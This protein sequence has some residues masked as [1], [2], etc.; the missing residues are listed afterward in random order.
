LGDPSVTFDY[1]DCGETV[2]LQYTQRVIYAFGRPNMG[3]WGFIGTCQPSIGHWWIDWNPTDGYSLYATLTTR[4]SDTA[5]VFT[6]TGSTA[7]A[8]A[9]LAHADIALPATNIMV[10]GVSIGL[11]TVRSVAGNAVTFDSLV[12]TLPAQG[13]ALTLNYGAYGWQ[14]LDRDVRLTTL[15]KGNY[16]TKD[17][18]VP[19]A[20]QLAKG[21][22]IP[23][24]LFLAG[25][26]GWF[27]DL[28]WPA[29]DPSR[30]NFSY[31][32]IPAGYRY[33]HGIDPPGSDTIR[34]PTIA[35]TSIQVF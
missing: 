3:N 17:A 23:K 14:E 19:A 10:G 18:G 27:G 21:D 34:T 4:T 7:S 2:G 24:S 32:A 29:F 12:G 25:K 15:L 5:G 16:N 35:T 31:D 11:A 1:V 8:H 13:T 6:T 26:P 20:E 9:V 28:A 30:P 33:V 22:T